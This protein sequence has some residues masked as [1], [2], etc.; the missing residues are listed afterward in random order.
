MARWNASGLDLVLLGIS[1]IVIHDRGKAARTV[2]FQHRIIHHVAE[3]VCYRWP[4]NA[5]K[6]PFR[7]ASGDDETSYAYV[8]A[9]LNE[10][11]SREVDRLRR[12][13]RRWCW[14]WCWCW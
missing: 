14:C 10:H 7:S 6:H 1:P 11:P 12:R 2:K 4:Q 13:L 8:I 3:P 5:E 9:G